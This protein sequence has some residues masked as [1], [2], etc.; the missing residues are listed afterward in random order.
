MTALF[1]SQLYCTFLPLFLYSLTTVAAVPSDV[2]LSVT[3]KGDI[4]VFWKS[5]NLYTELETNLTDTLHTSTAS[6]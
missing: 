4:A 2:S 3:E 5:V 6:H 1:T